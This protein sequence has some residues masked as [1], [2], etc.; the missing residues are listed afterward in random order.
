MMEKFGGVKYN[1]IWDESTWLMM[2]LVAACCIV[3]CIIDHS[4]W[5][6]IVCMAMLAFVLLTFLGIYYRIDGE[7]L[8]VYTF[9]IP[10]AYPIGKIKEIR[11]TKSIYY[12]LR[13]RR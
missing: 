7:K 3:P 8:V 2:G 5:L 10:T 4:L 1:S 13:Q 6:V 11:P 12:P 9:F